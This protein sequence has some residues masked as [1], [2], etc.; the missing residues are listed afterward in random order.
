MA[1][2]ATGSTDDM[3]AAKVKQSRAPNSNEPYNGV[4]LNAHRVNPMQIV[5]NTVLAMANSNMVP[6]LSKNGLKDKF[7][8]LSLKYTRKKK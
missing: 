7:I 5:L 2:T 8:E 1:R 4:K 6:I 3:R